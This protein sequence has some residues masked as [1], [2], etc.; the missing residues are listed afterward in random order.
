MCYLVRVVIAYLQSGAS[1]TV[2]R[3]NIVL[4][5]ERIAAE[6]GAEN[7]SGQR[8]EMNF[9]KRIFTIIERILLRLS[10]ESCGR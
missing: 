8:L 1:S 6:P 5:E 9:Y 7:L 4:S 10:V 2:S 3:S